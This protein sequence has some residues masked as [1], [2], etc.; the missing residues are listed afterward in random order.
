[1]REISP[2][3]I[4]KLKAMDPE[5]L[6]T[7]PLRLDVAARMAFLD[8]TMGAP[9]LRKERDKGWLATEMIAG[10]EFTTLADIEQMRELCRSDR[11]PPRG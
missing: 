6:L 7:K 8:G 11:R 1:M 10:K 4:A 2:E 9:G 3:L 5:A